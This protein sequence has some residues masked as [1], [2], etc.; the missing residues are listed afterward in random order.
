MDTIKTEGMEDN[1]LVGNDDDEFSPYRRE[2]NEDNNDCEDDDDY[3][4][5]LPSS[6][7]LK[8]KRRKRKAALPRRPPSFPT[9]N[10]ASTDES[11]EEDEGQEYT[12]PF[13]ML[14]TCS[15]ETCDGSQEKMDVDTFLEHWIYHKS[16]IK[17]Q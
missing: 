17:N 2:D 6:K 10:S 4:F 13:K 12:K 9:S 1:W 3:N 16:K 15:I 5:K 8:T 7:H 11:G 14:Y